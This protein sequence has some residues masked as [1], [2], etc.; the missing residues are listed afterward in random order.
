MG[1]HPSILSQVRDQSSGG[2]LRRIQRKRVKGW[3]M[4]EGAKCVTRPG[5]WG[6]PFTLE[7][8]RLN[9]RV[10][11]D[12]EARIDAVQTFTGWL[13]DDFFAAFLD[14]GE[15]PRRRKWMLANLHTLAGLSLACYC[16]LPADGEVDWCH[17]R[18]L[19]ELANGG[20]R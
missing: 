4:P 13:T 2:G 12:L 5:P 14:V 19:L 16:P 17:A 9:D 20:K 6:N 3:R 1:E 10:M 11:T 15:L 8:V 18:I 7:W